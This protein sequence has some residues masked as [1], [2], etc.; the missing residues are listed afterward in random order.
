MAGQMNLKNI[1]PTITV[2]FATGNRNFVS[3]CKI[4]QISRNDLKIKFR[5]KVLKVPFKK[6]GRG[7]MSKQYLKKSENL[8]EIRK[9]RG[10]MKILE[11]NNKHVP[12]D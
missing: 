2:H 12:R 4:R 9:N 7:L 8:G 1:N 6:F 5:K 3:S 11:K 10:K